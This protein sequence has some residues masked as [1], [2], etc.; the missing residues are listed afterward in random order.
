M[1][2]NY[3]QLT[4]KQ[5]LKI[6]LISELEQDP[7]HRKVLILSEISGVSVDEIESMPIGNMIEA[8]KGLDKIENLQAD[9]KIKL[10]FKVG[11]RKFIVKWKEQELT[12]EQ[13]IDVSHFCKEP[14]KILSNIHNILASV[15]VERNWY[16]KELGYKGDNHKEIADLFYNEMKIS[17]AYP[18]MLFFCKY[19]EALQQ[20]IL[21]YLE[22]EAMKAMD[23]T[24]ELMEK[25]KL[26]EQSGDGLPA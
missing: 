21:I 18:I 25:F 7:L 14:E 8:L 2:G 24:K 17:T 3:N 9:E 11:G 15:C 1:I 12:S 26:L 13:F 5:F 16:G 10:K 20:N 19:Y 22:S 4:I 23:S 6:K